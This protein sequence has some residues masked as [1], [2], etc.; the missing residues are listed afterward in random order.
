MKRKLYGHPVCNKCLYGFVNRR[1]IAY[2][3]DMVLLYVVSLFA[4]IAV[5]LL[6]VIV[7]GGDQALEMSSYAAMLGI[8]AVMLSKDGLNGYSPGKLLT[9]V[10]VFD[11][12]TGRPIGINLSFKRNVALMIPFAVLLAALQMNRGPRL[13][14]KF[15]KTKVVWVKYAHSPIFAV[16]PPPSE[17]TSAAYAPAGG[18]AP[19]APETGNP[20]QAPRA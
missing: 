19:L 11:E 4:G 14:D 7:G 15:A 1:Q 20:F 2:L 12:Q 9:G 17:E 16:G 18:N 13:G 5:G 6:V 8:M 10:Q 3:V